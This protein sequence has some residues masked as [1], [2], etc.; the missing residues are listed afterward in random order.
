MRVITGQAK[1]ARLKTPKQRKTR[2]TSSRVRNAIFAV[3]GP[4][5]GDGA[6]VLDLYAGSGALGIEALSRE[7]AWVDFVERDRRACQAIRQNLEAMG[8]KG[9]AHVHCKPVK[10]AVA[11][12]AEPYDIVLMDPPYGSEEV[13][14]IL[15]HLTETGLLRP[16]GV[17]VLEHA[18]RDAPPAPKGPLSLQKTRRYGDTAL[19]F[20]RQELTT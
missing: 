6:R 12:L 1:G 17:V 20:Y 2:P 15:N 7:A 19:T 9:Q 4:D 18:W 11:G 13:D 8:L 10:T 14:D 16:D 3:L 5:L